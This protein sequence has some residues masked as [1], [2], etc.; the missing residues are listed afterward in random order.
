VKLAR[1]LG[2]SPRRLW[3]WEP[4]TVTKHKY[5][6]GVVVKTV[7]RSESEWDVESYELL[8][9]LDAI[10]GD[11]HGPC[12][13]LLSESTSMD[14]NPDNRKGSIRYVVDEPIR[15]FACDALKLAQS[16]PDYS[17]DNADPAR[18][19]SVRREDR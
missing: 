10:E 8:A 19:W 15:C 6:D 16:S 7:S 3:G 17:G 13:H 14:A 5:K 1:Q 11:R 2:I 12:G 9:A 18:M 4:K